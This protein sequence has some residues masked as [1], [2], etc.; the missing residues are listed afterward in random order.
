MKNNAMY[1][2]RY[3]DNRELKRTNDCK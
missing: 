3:K 1:R 2:Y